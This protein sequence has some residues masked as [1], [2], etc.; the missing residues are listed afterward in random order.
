MNIEGKGEES[1]ESQNQFSIKHFTSNQIL[2]YCRNLIHFI[3]IQKNALSFVN[4]VVESSSIVLF[5][6]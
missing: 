6:S 5:N 1:L 2:S 4:H 3:I